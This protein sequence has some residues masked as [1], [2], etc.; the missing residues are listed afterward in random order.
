VQQQLVI[1]TAA[2]DDLAV[3]LDGAG[4]LEHAREV[5]DWAERLDTVRE[6]DIRSL[7]YSV[8]PAGADLGTTQAI[9]AMLRRLPPTVSTKVELGDTYR[10][11][12][13]DDVSPLPVAERLIVVYA[14]E[15]AVTNAL[16]HGHARSVVVR[17]DARAADQPGH[18]VLEVSVDDDGA[19]PAAPVTEFHGLERHR[20]RL[21]RRGG[22]LT[23]ASSPSG[24]GRLAF[25]LPFE[26]PE[27]DADRLRS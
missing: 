26:W 15:E 11:M 21:R 25:R 4:D 22:D 9:E 20:T 24:G 8:F 17:A 10:A 5:E 6:N 27:E 16:R 2:L 3:R 12:I 7:S 19:G 14:V 13:R 18:W 1:I 23:L